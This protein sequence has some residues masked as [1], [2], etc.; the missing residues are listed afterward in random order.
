MRRHVRLR[1]LALG[2]L[3]A[4]AVAAPALA[5]TTAA[6]G[7]PSPGCLPASTNDNELK[8]NCPDGKAM[9]AAGYQYMTTQYSTMVGTF[10]YI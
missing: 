7:P 3:A 9:S 2:A 4:L 5:T 6:P 1:L 10:S 8:D